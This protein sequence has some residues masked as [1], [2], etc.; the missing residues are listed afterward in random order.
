[1]TSF[2]AASALLVLLLGWLSVPVSLAAYEPDVC[3]MSCCVAAGHCCCT[4]R[5]ALV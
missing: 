1:M 2:Q 5:H 4:P 3:S